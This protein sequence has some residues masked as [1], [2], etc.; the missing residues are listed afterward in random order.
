MKAFRRKYLLEHGQHRLFFAS[1][2]N[3]LSYETYIVGSDQIWNP[4]ITC[5]LRKEYFGEFENEKKKK[6]IAYAT[7]MGGAALAERY[8]EEFSELLKNTGSKTAVTLFL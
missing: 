6:V 5:G 1:Q 7:S 2:L 4:D 8:D 3:R